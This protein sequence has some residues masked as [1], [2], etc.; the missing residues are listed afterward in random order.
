[1]K[2]GTVLYFSLCAITLF[3]LLSCND[4]K[5]PVSKEP[6]DIYYTCSMDPQVVEAKPGKCPICHMELTAVKKSARQ[7]ND[8]E[9]EL[10]PEQI[11][12]GNIQVDTV[13]NGAMGTRSVLT[14]TLNFDQTKINAVNARVAGRIEKLYFKNIGDYVPKGARL[15]ALYSE[16]LNNAKQEYLL[17]VQKQKILGNKVI[18]FDQVIESTKNKLLLWGM[19][20]E[21][22]RN[23]FSD[24]NEQ[25][26]SFY[27]T[28]A[29]YIT[30]LS[31]REGEYVAEGGSIVQLADLSSLWV[32][33]Q[34][35]AS[36]LGQ[37]DLSARA[38]IKIP[39]IPG[40]EMEGK[41][42]FVNPEINPDSRIN[43][44][45][46]KIANRNH[47]LKPGMSAYV[48][49][50]TVQ[51]KT[52]SLPVNAVLRDGKMAMIWVQTS[53]NKFM[54]RMVETGSEGNGFLE[55]KSGLKEGDNVVING[56]YLL[57]SEYIFR[58]GASP[59]AGMNMEGMKM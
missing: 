6:D 7:K 29:G 54:G 20:E 44:V 19:T 1:M 17:A 49:L 59:M 46:I 8:N 40:M 56:A 26:T 22:I 39:D 10:S 24:P 11:Q 12:L 15:Y 43:L 47:Q 18:D 51:Q 38:T 58:K 31:V 52:L 2:S 36:K 28:R 30:T 4:N 33:A 42:E 9:L 23:L 21:Q 45:R 48:I 32:E 34:V 14:G 50:N 5:K 3:L 41:I 16:E 57:Q 53:Q 27:S 35:Y 25:V 13:R 37:M 55:I